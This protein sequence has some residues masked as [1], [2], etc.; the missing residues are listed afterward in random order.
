ML[1]FFD[2]VYLTPL[3]NTM[4]KYS[5]AGYLIGGK[6]IRIILGLILLLYPMAKKTLS[7][8]SKMPCILLLYYTY[9]L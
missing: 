6:V 1:T 2:S 9:S 3:F 5:F 8:D 7:Y 4:T